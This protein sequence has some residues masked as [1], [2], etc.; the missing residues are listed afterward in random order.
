MR[1]PRYNWRQ[2]RRRKLSP[3]EIGWIRRLYRRHKFT[4]KELGIRYGV[5]QAAIYFI[6]M[7]REKYECL[8]KAHYQRYKYLGKRYTKEQ[9]RVVR[10]RK[11]MLM[12]RPVQDYYNERMRK[13]RRRKHEKKDSF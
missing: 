1:Y 4:Q 13:L 2:D 5:S 7:D 6:V 9:R 3:Y 10:K 8:K 12:F 11:R